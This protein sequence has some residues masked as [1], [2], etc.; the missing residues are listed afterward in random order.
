MFRV[1]TEREK[2]TIKKYGYYVDFNVG[3]SIEFLYQYATVYGDKQNKK[4]TQE[5]IEYLQSLLFSFNFNGLNMTN[6][7][8]DISMYNDLK[9]KLEL[10][11]EKYVT[12]WS[13]NARIAQLSKSFRFFFWSFYA[14]ITIYRKRRFRKI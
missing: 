10:T 5:K 6:Q 14:N 13:K 4:S 7:S 12:Y 3:R 8:S 11:N 2:P 9:E 1:L